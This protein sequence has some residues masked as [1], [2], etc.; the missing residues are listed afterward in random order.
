MTIR[1]RVM[2]NADGTQRVCVMNCSQSLG[3]KRSSEDIMRECGDCENGPRP[4]LDPSLRIGALQLEILQL[5]IALRNALHSI[6][7]GTS[8]KSLRCTLAGV[9]HDSYGRTG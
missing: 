3:D 9:L 7:A 2:V 8:R 1:P 6:D 5:R 4:P